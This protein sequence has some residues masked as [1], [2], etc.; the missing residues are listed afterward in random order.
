MKAVKNITTVPVKVFTETQEKALYSAFANHGKVLKAGVKAGD[1]IRKALTDA[2][3]SPYEL[4][5]TTNPLF[6]GRPE[7]MPRIKALVTSTLDNAVLKLIDMKA[8][9]CNDTI[10]Y[11]WADRLNKARLIVPIA[12][13]T[14]IQRKDGIKTQ[15]EHR[16]EWSQQP[17]ARITDYRNGLANSL[18][19]NLKAEGKALK[20]ETSDANG[21][22]EKGEKVK[23]NLI[24]QGS[25]N[26][27]HSIENCDLDDVALARITKKDFND[28]ARILNKLM[29]LTEPTH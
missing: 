21:T 28:L 7:V 8:G 4:Y 16:R 29:G 20:G 17:N 14:E 6:D 2:N 19:L 26:L 12:D 13:R 11:K 23:V 5:A 18:G 3:V 27:S 25:K 22:D 1:L 24:E 15:A 9:D 10:A